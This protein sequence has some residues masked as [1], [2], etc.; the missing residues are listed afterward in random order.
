MFTIFPMTRWRKRIGEKGAEKLLTE[1][2]AIAH[3]LGLLRSRDCERVIVDTTVQEK[4]ITHAARFEADQ[5]SSGE[6]GEARK[7]A[8]A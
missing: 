7:S 1:T 5:Q 4:N 2:L 8:G 3:K 6:L